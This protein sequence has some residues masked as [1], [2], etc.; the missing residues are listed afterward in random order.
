MTGAAS[1]TGNPE[2]LRLVETYEVAD[3]HLRAEMR[4]LDE[5]GAIT[6]EAS[7]T[8]MT[9]CGRYR[10]EIALFPAASLSDVLLKVRAFAL[11]TDLGEEDDDLRGIIEQRDGYAYAED[12]ARGLVVDLMRMGGGL[13]A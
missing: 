1:I 9:A 6:S 13:C 10:A 5:A 8:A 3:Q 12:I 2:L 4:R 7:G 11:T